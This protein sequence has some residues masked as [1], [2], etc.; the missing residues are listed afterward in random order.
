MVSKIYVKSL[1]RELGVAG[2]LCF[3]VRGSPAQSV[4]IDAVP[5]MRDPRYELP[6]P[7][8]REPS[9]LT[10]RINDALSR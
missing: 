10:T 3:G 1:C 7:Q 5:A 6:L 9:S 2:I 4:V 8:P